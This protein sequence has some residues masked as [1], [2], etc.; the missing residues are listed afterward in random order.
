LLRYLDYKIK[1][2]QD[3]I[4]EIIPILQKLFRKKEDSFPKNIKFYSRV[5]ALAIQLR[6]TIIIKL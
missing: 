3:S 1:R 6:S 4:G 2:I 5:E